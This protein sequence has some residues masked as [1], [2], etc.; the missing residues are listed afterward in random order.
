MIKGR[1]GKG[2]PAS[3]ENG[4]A[5]AAASVTAP[6]IPIQETTAGRC[7][8]G[9]GSCLSARPHKTQ[10]TYDKGKIQTIRITITARPTMTASATS[11][12]AERLESESRMWCNC[13]PTRPKRSAFKTKVAI[14]HAAAP[15]NRDCTLVSSGVRQP[16][17]TPTVTTEST[18]ETPRAAAGRKAKYPERSEIVTST[19]G[20]SRRRLTAAI[21]KPITRPTA[22]PPAAVQRKRQPAS[23]I[24]KL[25]ETTAT[26]ATR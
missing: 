9:A 12:A 26:T 24:E 14:C 17:Y 20:L 16:M 10:G 15:S 11:S 3:V 2:S 22:T 18:P 21:R 19:G 6:R 7:Q 13:S 4:I 8:G 25:P 1:P 5:S 23:Q